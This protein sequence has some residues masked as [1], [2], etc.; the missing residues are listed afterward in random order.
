MPRFE[1]TVCDGTTCGVIGRSNDPETAKKKLKRAVKKRAKD[2]ELQDVP[3]GVVRGEVRELHRGVPAD[4]AIYEAERRYG[5]PAK[6]RRKATP[7]A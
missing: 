5:P 3:E 4:E 1:I 7:D 6:R 2:L